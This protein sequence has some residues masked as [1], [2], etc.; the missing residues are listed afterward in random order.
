MDLKVGKAILQNRGKPQRCRREETRK[1]SAGVNPRARLS[2]RVCFLA[3][4]FCL[5]FSI[6]RRYT[7]AHGPWRIR[8][9]LAKLERFSVR[10]SADMSRAVPPSAVD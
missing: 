7:K 8:I 6:Y 3:F 4:G 1:S 5:L 2:N 9:G 10:T